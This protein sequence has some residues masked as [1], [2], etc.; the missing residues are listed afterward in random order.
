MVST[1]QLADPQGPGRLLEMT[2]STKT[3]HLGTTNAV[4]TPRHMQ[5]KRRGGA[6]HTELGLVLGRGR[7]RDLR[8]RVESAGVALVFV[9]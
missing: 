7:L 8:L 1:R 5:M 6:A 2:K 4:K 3:Q 9:F